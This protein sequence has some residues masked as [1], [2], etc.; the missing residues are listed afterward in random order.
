MM[1][2]ENLK[3]TLKTHVMSIAAMSEFLENRV[4]ELETQFKNECTTGRID[5]LRDLLEIDPSG[6][7]A[8]R[9]VTL[10][11]FEEDVS[12]I[13][14]DVIRGLVSGYVNTVVDNEAHLAAAHN[15]REGAID[16]RVVFHTFLVNNERPLPELAD[17]FNDSSFRDVVHNAAT[18][19]IDR[20]WWTKYHD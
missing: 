4:Q 18:G 13:P 20:T 12:W 9:V 7:I 6:R 1:I 17:M 16:M 11:E 10:L 19:R 8:G 15:C 5:I 14:D 2:E 3:T